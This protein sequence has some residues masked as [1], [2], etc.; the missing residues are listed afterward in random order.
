[1]PDNALLEKATQAAQ[2]LAEKP[3]DALTACKKLLKH[4]IREQLDTAGRLEADEFAV[5][6]RSPEAKEAFD[7]FFHKRRPDFTK[8]K[9]TAPIAKS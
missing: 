2:K 4:T 1:V 9:T 7:A 6:V 3:I 8:F 5:R